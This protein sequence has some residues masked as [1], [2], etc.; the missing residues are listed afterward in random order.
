MFRVAQR[1]AKDKCAKITEVYD[2]LRDKFGTA[3]NATRTTNKV[4]S[5]LLINEIDMF[6]K[7]KKLMYVFMCVRGACVI[8]LNRGHNQTHNYKQGCTLN[9]G[10][11]SIRG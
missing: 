4:S 6:L 8:A 5:F 3:E 11:S 10:L 9:Q 1:F 2:R 7:C